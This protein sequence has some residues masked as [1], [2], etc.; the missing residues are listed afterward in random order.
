MQDVIT[1]QVEANAELAIKISSQKDLLE[2]LNRSI[3]QR[4]RQ[5]ETL[6]SVL[7]SRDRQV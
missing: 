5:I 4:E 2:Y 7:A 3:E 1:K 6:L